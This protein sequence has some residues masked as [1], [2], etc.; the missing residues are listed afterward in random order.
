MR[1]VALLAVFASFGAA[2][3]GGGGGGDTGPVTIALLAPKTG[4]LSGVGTSFESVF[5]VAV[6]DVNEQGGVDGRDLIGI[7]LDTRLAVAGAPGADETFQDAVDMGAVAV[8]GPAAS[9]EVTVAYPVAVTD[10]VPLISPSSTAPALSSASLNP[11][12]DG[13]MF[14]NVPD[15]DIQGIAMAY[16]LRSERIPTVATVSVLYE[17]TAYGIGLKNAFKIQFEDQGGTVNTNEVSFEPG[18]Q[19]MCCPAATAC[20]DVSCTLEDFECGADHTTDDPAGPDLTGQPKLCGGPDAVAAINDLAGD[21]PELVVMI[22]LEQDAAELA[23]AWDNDGGTPLIANMQFFMT[24]GARSS[25]FLDVAPVTVRGMCGSAP[26]FPVSGLAYQALKLAFETANPGSTVEEQVFAPNVWDATHLLAMALAQQA[27]DF[28]DD[29]LGGEHLRDAITPVSKGGSIRRADEWRDILQAI[30][31]G[32][33][34]DYDG[35][36]GPNDFDVVGQAIGPYEVWCVSD[37]GS[38][39]DQVL[40]LEAETLMSL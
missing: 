29:T 4:P 24:D 33:D 5:N 16:Y 8:V 32:T 21:A 9:G 20:G 12:D 22:A 14:R 1:K 27:N 37:N 18:L 11:S 36:A 2:G 15:D 13:Y 6:D 30:R 3:C 23:L 10:E 34:I 40:F 25:G 28:P 38:T 35:A 26:T 31:A 7:T 39:F 17:N 19:H